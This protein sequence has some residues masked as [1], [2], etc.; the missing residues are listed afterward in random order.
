MLK[1]QPKTLAKTLD[2]IA[3]R[4]PG[5]YGLFWD[6]DGSMP[7]KEFYWALQED[8]SLRFVREATIRELALLGIQLGFLLDGNRLRLVSDAVLPVYPPASQVPERLYF[9]VRPKRLVYVQHNG[10]RGAGRPLVA[11]CADRELALRMAKRRE[12]S[13][14]LVEIPAR[15]ALGK[16]LCLFD[17]GPHLYLTEF[18]PTEFIV[19]PKIRGDLSEK[20]AEGSVKHIAKPSPAPASPGSFTVQPHHIHGPQPV[21]KGSKKDARGAGWKKDSRKERHKRD[22]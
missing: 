17:A 3:R 10:L 15:E 1:H 5:E 18:V 22:L 19:F 9:G 4:S 2:Y 12:D 20:L 7:W 14:I 16:G 11:L 13:P 6:P 8:P 21:G